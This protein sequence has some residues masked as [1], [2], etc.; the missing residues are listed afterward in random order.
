MLRRFALHTALLILVFSIGATAPVL[1]VDSVME[2]SIFRLE[3]PAGWKEEGRSTPLRV[4][5]PNSEVLLISVAMPAPGDANVDRMIDTKQMVQFWKEK[6]RTSLVGAT[7][8]QGMKPTEPFTERAV[9]GLPLFTAKSQDEQRG[10][11]LSC[12]GLV[13]RGGT[14]FIITVEGWLRNKSTAEAAVEGMIKNIVWKRR[15]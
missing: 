7:S 10:S 5:G 1:A 11:F 3:L 8:Q 9:Q 6:I 15:T 4:R 13:G 12:Y 14:V 2:T